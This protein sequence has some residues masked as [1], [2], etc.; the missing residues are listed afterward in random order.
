MPQ[1]SLSQPKSLSR[2]ARV[3]RYPQVIKDQQD[4]A[5]SWHIFWATLGAP[6][7]LMRVRAVTGAYPA[8]FFVMVLIDEVMAPV[9]DAPVARVC[10]KDT[11]RPAPLFDW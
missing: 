5:V 8:A 11:W 6:L 9:F 3:F 2:G 10:G 1:V 4:I 7:A